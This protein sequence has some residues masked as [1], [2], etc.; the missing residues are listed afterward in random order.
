MKNKREFG[1]R[2]VGNR[3]RG[4]E[5]NEQPHRRD[6]KSIA[7]E[8]L[9]VSS[10]CDLPEMVEATT[11]AV[12]WFTPREACCSWVRFG[13]SLSAFTCQD[14]AD[15]GSHNIEQQGW[16]QT[17]GLMVL[18]K[19]MGSAVVTNQL[20][21]N[22]YLGGQLLA[23]LSNIKNH[24]WGFPGGVVVKNPSANAGNTGLSPGLGRSH[25]SWSN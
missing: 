18:D 12:A 16:N 8:R 9:P 25:M 10:I 1:N 24:S 14:Q 22:R 19:Y 13:L 5:C 15:L 3:N 6:E 2:A 17:V 23:S 21:K 20:L 11:A 4:E 7:S